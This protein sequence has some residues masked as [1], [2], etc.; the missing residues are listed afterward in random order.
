MHIPKKYSN[1]ALQFGTTYKTFGLFA[2][3]MLIDH[4]KRVVYGMCMF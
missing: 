2:E 4:Q 1:F 3:Q